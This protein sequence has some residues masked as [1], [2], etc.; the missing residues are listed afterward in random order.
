MVKSKSKMGGRK[1][2]AQKN[3]E[4]GRK[5]SGSFVEKTRTLKPPAKGWGG[6]TKT[7]KS[8]KVF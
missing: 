1:K 6:G 8:I 3:K 7:K 2:V 5:R 4:E